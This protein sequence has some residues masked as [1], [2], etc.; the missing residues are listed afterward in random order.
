MTTP[1]WRLSCVT[2]PTT[3]TNKQAAPHSQVSSQP[4]FFSE[5]SL[6]QR[7]ERGSFQGDRIPTGT[8]RR[9]SSAESNC[10][11]R[12]TLLHDAKCEFKRHN[13]EKLH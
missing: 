8:S 2:I 11:S 6:R 10:C 9:L 12:E 13:G 4:C 3:S 5:D 7:Q 1:N